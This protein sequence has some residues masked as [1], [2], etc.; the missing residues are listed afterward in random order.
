M[1]T[2]ALDAMGGDLRPRMKILKQGDRC[3]ARDGADTHVDE[4]T[5]LFS[6]L[7]RYV[8][9]YICLTRKRASS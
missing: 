9:N 5:M 8:S 2:V 3:C 7:S 4:I 1:I 6:L